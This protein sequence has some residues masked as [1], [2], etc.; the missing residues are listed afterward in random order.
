MLEFLMRFK[1]G[2]PWPGKI[3]QGHQLTHAKS[4]QPFI[5]QRN[6]SKLMY[7]P[8]KA[9]SQPHWYICIV[10]EI[11]EKRK[12]LSTKEIACIICLCCQCSL[13]RCCLLYGPLKHEHFKHHPS[14]VLSLF[15]LTLILLEFG[16]YSYYFH[17]LQNLIIIKGRLFQNWHIS[18]YNF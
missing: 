8:G 3:N 15:L 12:E 7:K 14:V 4:F 2:S 11:N 1:D 6:Y 10:W 9:I 13:R 16:F 17:L 18:G 5:L